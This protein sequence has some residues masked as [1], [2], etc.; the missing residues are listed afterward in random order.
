MLEAVYLIKDN[1][2]FTWFALLVFFSGF[3]FSYLVDYFN[4][5]FLIWFPHFFI[6]L[7]SKYVNPRSS[8]IKI[9]LVIFLF[10]SIS[11]A[12]YMSSGIFVVLPYIIAFFTGMNIGISVFI[13]PQLNIEGYEV[14]PA[15]GI[16]KALRMILFSSLVFI[17]EIIVFSLALGMGM[18]LGAAVLS[19][20]TLGL[21]AAMFVGELLLIRV[22]AYLFICVPILA[23]SACMEASV[24]KG[25]GHRKR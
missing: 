22:K 20:E 13:P 15:H 14:H 12:L 7:L 19:V 10:N 18:S 9:F 24:I 17:C 5:E 21:S 25:S 4:I 6:K 23:L 3:C 16:G 1:I 11:I 8:F 2:Y